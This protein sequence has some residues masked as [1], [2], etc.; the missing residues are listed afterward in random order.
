[1]VKVEDGDCMKNM[2]DREKRDGIIYKKGVK[3]GGSAVFRLMWALKFLYLLMLELEVSYYGKDGDEGG[4]GKSLRVCM[5]NAYEEVFVGRH[6]WSVRKSVGVAMV[7]LPGRDVFLEK[8]G[9]FGEKMK[10]ECLVRLV[11][12]LERLCGDMWGFYE[13]NGLLDIP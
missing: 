7:F 6:S 1:M 2:I 4:K 8:I 3:S 13:E 11:G 9:V 5:G 10:R 12:C